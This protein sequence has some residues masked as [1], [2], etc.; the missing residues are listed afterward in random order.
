[1]R[2]FALQ[3]TLEGQTLQL[4]P[5]R[6]TD[7]DALYAVASDPLVWQQHPSP[8]R[9]QLPVFEQLFQDALASQG[10]LVA[11]DRAAERAIGWSRYYDLDEAA[12]EVAIGYTFL[13]RAYWGGKA[14]GEMKKLMLDHA[15]QTLD[16][17][18]FH[19]GPKNI[20]SQKA[21]LKIGA[22]F[23]HEGTKEMGGKL[24]EYF[25][26]KMTRNEYAAC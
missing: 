21:L 1:M 24:V 25:F 5:L 22:T 2:A 9:Y 20:R 6:S 12:G 11:I 17:V 10:T 3:P 19:V 4:R 23:S 15:F 14:N 13:G 16:T 18:W 8:N 26:Y 7:F